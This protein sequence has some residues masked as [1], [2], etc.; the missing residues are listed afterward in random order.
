MNHFLILS[1]LTFLGCQDTNSNSYDKD[2]YSDTVSDSNP[3][4]KAAYTVLQNRCITCHY[5]AAWSKNDT[6]EKWIEQGL[7]VSQ[8]ASSSPIIYKIYNFGGGSSNMPLGGS[9]GIP[10]SE[11]QAL[12][13]WVEELQ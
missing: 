1:M 12:L 13:D 2:K 7:V 10:G 4:F 11:Y 9:T 3:T 5:H 6:P 8:D